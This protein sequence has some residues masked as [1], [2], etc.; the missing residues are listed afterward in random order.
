[1]LQN[2]SMLTS[3]VI[4]QLA[5]GEVAPAAAWLCRAFGFRER[6]RIGTHRVQLT[7]PGGGSLV[8]TEGGSAA[9]AGA[10]GYASHRVMVR[11]ADIDSHY[12]HAAA[13]G[14][15]ILSAP[16]DYPYGERQYSA[17]D[18]GGHRWDFSQTLADV[19]PSEWGGELLER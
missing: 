6:L 12:H 4:P 10:A 5:Y 11:V 17:L 9:T 15:K 18:P 1:M 19:D 2:R 16:R 8:V 7:F 13:H 3:V 14:A